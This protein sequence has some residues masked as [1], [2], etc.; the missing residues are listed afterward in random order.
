MSILRGPVRI[1]L[2]RSAG[3]AYAEL[4]LDIP[5]HLVAANNV[6]KT[7]LITALQFLYIDD[8]RTMHFS[9]SIAETKKHY[10]REPNSLVLFECMTPTGLQVL[11]ARG[12]GPVQGFDY[13]LFVYRGEYARADYRDG[14][15]LRDWEEVKVR[16]I[17]RDLSFLKPRELRASLMGVGDSRHPPLGIVPLKQSST[18]ESFQFLFRN[19]LRLSRIEKEQLKRLF[20]DIVQPLIHVTGLDLRSQYAG[21]YARVELETESIMALRR[22]EPR[23]GELAV[24]FEMQKQLHRKLVTRW[25]RLEAWLAAERTRSQE[26]RE[27]L[28][29]ER[30]KCRQEIEDCHRRHAEL[31]SELQETSKKHGVINAE[32]TRLDELRTK[33]ATFEPALE[34]A[35]RRNL[36]ARRDA[37]I[38]RLQGPQKV[39]RARLERRQ[40]ELE[41]DIGANTKLEEHFSEAVVTWLRQNAGLTDPQ[42]DDVF[43]LLDPRLLRVLTGP[44]QVDIT[45][46]QSLVA[47]L[48]ALASRFTSDGYVSE[49]LRIS[50][51]VLGSDSS[52]A[53]YSN[54]DTIRSRLAENRKEL[55]DTRRMLADLDRRERLEKERTQLQT[56]LEEASKRFADWQSWQAAESRRPDLVRDEGE[57]ASRTARC[58]AEMKETM[59]KV[60]DLERAC[61]NIENRIQQE[62]DAF[63]QRLAAVQALQPPGERED[64]VSEID[65]EDASLDEHIASYGKDWHSH[66]DTSHKL[67]RLHGEVEQQTSGRYSGGTMA[68]IIERLQDELKALPDRE[69]VV[70]NLWASLIDQMKSGFKGL[71]RG[72][73]EIERQVSRLNAALRKRQI[74]NLRS[75]TLEMVRQQDILGRI[76]AVLAVDETPL[77]AGR[78]G[79]SRA[80]ADFARWLDERPKI[81]LGD[82]FDLQFRVVTHDGT[83]KVF[84]SLGQIES[85]GTGTTIKVLIHLEL[86]K[87]MLV[88]DRV[89][90]PFFLDEVAT[91]DHANLRAL[92]EHATSMSFVPVIA[93]PEAQDCV[94][95]LYFIR[96]SSTSLVLDENSCV[97]WRTA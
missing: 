86:L 3:Y 96:P 33:C 45:D 44:N 75:V 10:F 9:H 82:L 47:E 37:L 85:E 7:S 30:A 17:G 29:G 28:E 22:I 52:L 31:T 35:A 94:E 41:R 91:L 73:E 43:R 55:D 32:L 62:G 46:A 49:A 56:Q 20:I 78:E 80:A 81:E 23:I 90:V 65:L 24:A 71:V 8:V 61:L 68:E 54:L 77:F 74:S 89:S 51:G 5:V 84:T 40:R 25:Q 83:A 50:R 92:V 53:E 18:Y 48:Q 36:E 34:E 11:G 16:L 12:L 4:P 59:Q 76:D 58:D 26:A 66:R 15:T 27:R 72:V 21:L 39:D 60:S 64:V 42:L 38:G 6:G 95:T 14:A 87:M 19:L 67:E 79:R 97:T 93:S 2:I 88:E 70:K 1:V 13:E 57:L 69:V 63:S